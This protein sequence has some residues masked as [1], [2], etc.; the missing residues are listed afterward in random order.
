MKLR[1]TAMLL[2][3]FLLLS[4]CGKAEPAT[5]TTVPVQVTVTEPAPEPSTQATTLPPE[6]QTVLAEEGYKLWDSAD[7][8]RGGDWR[9][10]GVEMP[11]SGFI[12]GRYDD[13]KMQ[14]AIVGSN[15]KEYRDMVDT[16]V[17][18]MLCEMPGSGFDDSI[19]WIKENL[20]P[21]RKAYPESKAA[22]PDKK[23]V[24]AQ[25]FYAIDGTQL[26][27]DTIGNGVKM[28]DLKVGFTFPDMVD[29]Y[30][31]AAFSIKEQYKPWEPEVGRWVVEHDGQEI[32]IQAWYTMSNS[33]DVQ[34][35]SHAKL[36]VIHEFYVLVP[37]DY[38]GLSFCMGEYATAENISRLIHDDGGKSNWGQGSILDEAFR[39]C[40]D[41]RFH[42]FGM[43]EQ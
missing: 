17:N 18:V 7:V 1:I 29:M 25:I 4:G 34:E 3:C 6:P 32:E 12:S 11:I 37:A 20:T 27:Q 23:L 16:Q 41:F 28:A 15:G 13:V 26:Y 38:E 40:K 21:F 43:N 39:E 33:W 36:N 22:E 5:E 8:S 19:D 30:T 35:G 42:F 24:Y 9:Y 2:V 31:G 14:F 10:N